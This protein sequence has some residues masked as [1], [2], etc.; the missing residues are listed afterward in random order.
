MKIAIVINTYIVTSPGEKSPFD[1]PTPLWLFEKENTLKASLESLRDANRRAEDEYTLYLFGIA[2]NERID[3]DQEIEQKIKKIVENVGGLPRVH[4]ISNRQVADFR[5]QT[6]IEFFESSGYPEIRNLGFLIPFMF[7][8]DVI[9]QLDDDELIRENHLVRFAELFEKNPEYGIV[10]APYEQN[11]SRRI[12]GEDPLTTWKKVSS[13]D[14]DLKKLLST[15][16][17]SQTLFGLGGNLCIRSSVAKEI[18]Y[19]RKVPRGEDFSLLLAARLLYENGDLRMKIK[20]GNRLFLTWFCSE[21][22]VTILHQPPISER[23]DFLRSF[24]NN[25]RRFILER[26][27]VMTQKKFTLSD[28]K[29]SSQ[30]LYAMFGQEDFR[31][32]ILDW[33]D[34]IRM[35]REDV[36][37]MKQLNEMEE[38]LLVF[39]EGVEKEP[40][41]S[42]Y[43]EERRRF[44]KGQ[45]WLAQC[46]Q[47]ELLMKIG[48]WIK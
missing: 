24:E 28:L 3:F 39:L 43:L 47:E 33:I 8:E 18:F 13:M 1:H 42:N 11:G 22:D 38:R 10:T 48:G 34:T 26:Q 41:W 45:A 16:D 4:V 27:M 44:S 19:P 29:D 12:I 6:E 17:C 46:D 2:A 23:E 20:P 32:Q 5:Q 15:D 36:T 37:D 21:K 9:M 40:R 7:H 31:R 35:E 25:I 14:A 30:Y